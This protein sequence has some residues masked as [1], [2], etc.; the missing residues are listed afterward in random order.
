MG[1]AHSPPITLPDSKSDLYRLI[2]KYRNAHTHAYHRYGK[3]VERCR[4]FGHYSAYL[5]S[6]FGVTLL[7]TKTRA[8]IPCAVVGGILFASGV[9]MTLPY[10][11]WQTRA[12]EHREVA[13][14]LFIMSRDLLHDENDTHLQI[15]K[16]EIHGV[17]THAPSLI[18][19][20]VKQK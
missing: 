19:D 5:G 13:D 8:M 4:S 2:E 17:I 18:D 12:S 15:T 7:L 9:S 3:R 16:S 1:N 11:D 20:D 6:V 14:K 10:R